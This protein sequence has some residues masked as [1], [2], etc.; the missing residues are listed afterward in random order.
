MTLIDRVKD[1]VQAAVDAGSGAV[2]DLKVERRRKAL[3]AE[4]G[5]H[6]YDLVSKGEVVNAHL[7]RLTAEIDA[8]D[9]VATDADDI[10]SDASE[11]DDA[12]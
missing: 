2:S 7:V 12:T 1:R 8:L 5:D 10:E 3:V 11:S 6:A 4:M 9:A